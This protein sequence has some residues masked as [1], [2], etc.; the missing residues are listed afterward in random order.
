M[1]KWHGRPGLLARLG[2]VP[3]IWLAVAASGPIAGCSREPSN[4]G[5]F[6]QTGSVGLNLTAAPGVTLN[7]VT[8]TITGNGF[9][10]TGAIDTSGSPTIS[11]TIGGIPAGKG[12][13]ITLTAT[14]FEGDTAF[15]GSARFD[16][17][18]GGSVVGDGPPDGHQQD[19]QRQ[20]DGERHHQRAPAHRRG[21]RDTPDGV[22]RQL[23]HAVG[24]WHAT[25][26][27]GRHP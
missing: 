20:R 6:E 15:T 14:S 2:K 7:S 8:Y 3:L 23:H 1:K 4:H 21:D 18:A 27:R 17:T 13:T 9:T 10:K 26:T 16:V 5:D 22:R 12:Y 24:R 19:R 25:P 11:G